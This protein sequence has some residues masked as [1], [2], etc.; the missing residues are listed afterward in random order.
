MTISAA[1]THGLRRSPILASFQAIPRNLDTRFTQVSLHDATRGQDAPFL[2]AVQPGR[3]IA[4]HVRA[5]ADGEQQARQQAFKVEKRALAIT[6]A[7]QEA[8]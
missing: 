1:E 8:E 7:R 6:A 3:L 4:V 2:V 5:D